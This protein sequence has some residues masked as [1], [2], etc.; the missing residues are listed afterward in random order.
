[1]K[2]EK[3]ECIQC[4]KVNWVQNSR[5]VCTECVYKNNHRGMS[6]IEVS[7]SKQRSKPF[8]MNKKTGELELFKEIWQ[9]RAHYCENLNCLKFLGHVLNIQFFSHRKSKGAYPELRLSKKNIDL[10]CV[11]CHHEWEFGDRNK[12][13]L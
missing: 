11:S 6:R 13:N 8:K 3:K 2:T 9:E 10:L 4:S 12:I 5:G 1:M 7:K